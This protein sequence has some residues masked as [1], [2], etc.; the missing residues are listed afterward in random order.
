MQHQLEA[1]YIM[2]EMER[3]GKGGILA[4]EMGCG[5]TLTMALFLKKNKVNNPDLIVCPVSMVNSWKN[6]ILRI[7]DYEGE[8]NPSI[9]VYRGK[10]RE[11]KLRS[12]NWDY[13][14]TTYSII[15]T[16][17]L[18]KKI[19][20]RVVLDESHTIK[21][22]LARNPPK[23]AKAAFEIGKRSYRN[24]CI[25]GTPFNNRMND[26]AAQAKFIGT[27][28]FCNPNWWKK[29]SEYNISLWRENFVLR[30]TKEGMLDPPE[31]Y[32]IQ[33]TPLPQEVEIVEVL[34]K[35]AAEKFESW[36]A[37]SGLNKISL[38]GHILGLITK[39]RLVSDSYFCGCEGFDPEDIYENNAKVRR[40]TDDIERQLE[41]DPRNG[42]VVFSQFT[43]FLDVMEE[44]L[45]EKIFM[46][47]VSRITGS[48]SLEERDAVIRE[49]NESDE[50]RIILVSLMAGGVGISLHHGS[51]SVF[52][53]EPYFNPFIEQQAEERVHRLGQ[54]HQVK[55]F[56]YTMEN[57]VESWIQELKKTKLQLASSLSLTNMEVTKGETFT[58]NDLLKL[59]RDHV[60]FIKED[61]EEK[62]KKRKGRKKVLKVP[63]PKRAPKK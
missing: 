27:R 35:N 7:K 37:A 16:D 36:R 41:E 29:N 57:S 48:M 38:Q 55:V 59:F 12:E 4:D 3:R 56:R 63:K 50:P 26:L 32:D 19:W 30:R 53:S 44:V 22:G 40:M 2:K 21:N 28:P 60:G 1:Q 6:E 39:L 43:K 24:W 13:V 25:S 34:R 17:D 20:G 51:S 18:N 58:F 42:V 14:I 45:L 49:F 9:L 15:S 33:V 5:K 62:K 23:C 52:I 11:E 46:V 31:Y 8:T 10:D 54:K 47:S 61:E